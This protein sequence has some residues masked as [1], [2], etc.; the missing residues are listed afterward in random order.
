MRKLPVLTTLLLLLAAAATAAPL[1]GELPAGETRWTG[2]VEVGA[3]LVVPA[4][5]TLTIKAGATVRFAPGAE[6][7]VLGKLAALGSEEKPIRFLPA[8]EGGRWSGLFFQ[9]APPGSE[10]AHCRFVGAGVVEVTGTD[11][12]IR[13]S[14]IEKG[15]RGVHFQMQGRSRFEE[16]TVRDIEKGGVEV[17]LGATAL[18]EGNVIERCGEFGV[19]KGPRSGPRIRKNIVRD[20][21]VGIGLIGD[22]A[23]V[24]ENTV[25]KCRLGITVAQGTPEMIV[26][27]NTV[28]ECETGILLTQFAAPVVTDNVV[29]KCG[30]G[31]R[32]F[33]A[34]SPVIAN[35][36]VEGNQRGI[37][38]EQLCEPLIEKNLILKNKTG[39]YLTLSSYAPI[40]QNHFE[41]NE[42]HIELGN[43]SSDWEKRSGKKPKRS[44]QAQ[45]LTMAE[46]G[47]AVAQ[48]IPDLAP[49]EGA[50]DAG[51]NWW[52]EATTREMKEK[53]AN[54]D[55]KAI[56]DYHDVPTRT[57]EGWEGEFVQD[58]VLYGGW[59]DAPPAD[60]GPRPL[61]PFDEK[62]E[63][64]EE[65]KGEAKPA[66]P[67][68]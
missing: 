32:C 20:S 40:R 46:R 23:L 37:V 31:M 61:P 58:K 47:K 18:V 55:I 51:G 22:S 29:T 8:A 41:G 62:D 9:N 16:N 48:N 21:G 68:Q 33:Q 67:A 65:A 11:L 63:A 7:R 5:A 50:V 12:F 60:A 26:A 30:D 10:L 28:T 24:V 66:A 36:R 27:G 52:G 43:M 14:V 54:A 15:A 35:N 57:Y 44:R 56:R 34:S 49:V 2:A 39:I 38:A 42:T 6:L 4:N 3:P 53:G 13:R 59:L 25:E 45:N 19:G 64:K 1:A 17:N